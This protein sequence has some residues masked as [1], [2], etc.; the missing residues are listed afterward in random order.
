MVAL[1]GIWRAPPR[2]PRARPRAAARP[3]RPLAGSL[4]SM[5]SAPARGREPRLALVRH[6]GKEADMPALRCHL[7]L[8][9]VS[10]NIRFCSAGDLFAGRFVR[11]AMS[12]TVSSWTIV[13]L[14]PERRKIR[15]PEHHRL[16]AVMGNEKN[17]RRPPVPER[18]QHL[19]Q[20]LRRRIVERDERL[21]HQQDVGLG[22]EAA[23][24]RR[25][26][27]H[28]EREALGILRCERLEPTCR[29]I[30]GMRASAASPSGSASAMFSSTVRQGS[31]RGDWKI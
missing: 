3:A 26:P 19:A 30:S 4:Q 5:M 13:A 11:P 23:R 24:Q 18:D 31:S 25:A 14:P 22:D 16:A 8:A 29:S 7:G 27:L 12:R 28:A 1:T 6:A 15:V 21:V 2:A 20:P 17:G 10:R 9:H